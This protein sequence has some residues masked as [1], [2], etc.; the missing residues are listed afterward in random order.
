MGQFG[1]TR[2]PYQSMPPESNMTSIR[3]NRASPDVSPFMATAMARPIPAP[4]VTDCV[5]D[6]SPD[7]M[8]ESHNAVGGV[9]P[10]TEARAVETLN[11]PAGFAK[12]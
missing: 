12:S 10:H 5:T 6:D 8:A 7:Q 2:L 1:R 9:G 3:S 11:D 4:A